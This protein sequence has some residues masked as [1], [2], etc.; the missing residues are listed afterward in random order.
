M[1]S[2][3][4]KKVAELDGILAIMIINSGRRTA[5]KE[6]L[7]ISAWPECHLES[8]M[9]IVAGDS[10]EDLASRKSGAYPGSV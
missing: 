2:E 10:C 1:I 4:L 5:S 3:G 6:M 7:E 9:K 8:E